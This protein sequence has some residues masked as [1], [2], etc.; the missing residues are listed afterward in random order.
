MMAERRYYEP[1][2]FA[3]ELR[4]EAH[5]RVTQV[6]FDNLNARLQ[7]LEELLEKLERRLW[8]AVYGVVAMMLAEAVQS[9]VAVVP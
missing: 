1:V 7:R 2:T 5:E 8:L 3:P 4:L 6:H 9:Y